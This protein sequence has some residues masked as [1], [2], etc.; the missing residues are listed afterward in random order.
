MER[1]SIKDKEG[2]L[3]IVATIDDETIIDIEMQMQNQHNMTERTLF[4]GSG[5]YYTGLKR[6][7]NYNKNKKVITINILNFNLFKDGPYHEKA[8]LRREYGNILLT[9]KLELHF[10]Q[11]PK[12]IKEGSE[13]E[14]KE[15]YQWMVFISNINKKEVE[16]VMQENKE[17]KKVAQELEDLNEDENVRIFALLREKARRDYITN[18]ECEREDAIREG[19]EEGLKNGMNKEKIEIAKKMIKENIDIEIIKKVTGLTNMDIE[20]IYANNKWYNKEGNM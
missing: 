17:I 10:I 7:E 5:L 11:I 9:D 2:I 20:K 3:D 16:R 18:L 1:N 14:N 6:S 12:F 13:K 15:L 4:Y 19:L 8:E